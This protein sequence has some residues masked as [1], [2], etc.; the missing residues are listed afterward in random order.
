MLGTTSEPSMEACQARC[1]ST[2][3]CMTFT[4][5]LVPGKLPKVAGD[6]RLQSAMSWHSNAS[7][8]VLSGPARF[9]SCC[10]E[11]P[12]L[13]DA[14]FTFGAPAI[15]FPAAS[16]PGGRC[17]PGVRMYT[18]NDRLP[19]GGYGWQEDAAA[20]HT[21]YP[22]AKTPVF[23]LRD[24]NKST[25]QYY[26]CYH[27]PMSTDQLVERMPLMKGAM[28]HEWR[29]H[30]ITDVYAKRLAGMSLPN[31]SRLSKEKLDKYIQIGLNLTD[32]AD[33]TYTQNLS[34]AREAVRRDLP[35]WKLVGYAS[36]MGK[37]GDQDDV[38]LL[39]DEESGDCTISFE[40]SFGM[41]DLGSF[42]SD[43]GTGY[44]GFDDVHVGVRNELW[45]ITA[46]PGKPSW[47]SGIKS[48]LPKCRK[49]ICV[50]HSLGGALCELFTLCANSNR[51]GDPDF[52]KLAWKKVEPQLMPEVDDYT[53]RIARLWSVERGEPVAHIALPYWGIAALALSM[54][55][56]M[57]LPRTLHARTGDKEISI[58]QANAGSSGASEADSTDVEGQS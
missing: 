6:C 29:L 17:I 46:K 30:G 1:A 40:G 51:F 5:T 32:M 11:T 12:L 19:G 3:D 55:L 7:L 24:A 20:M 42:A 22:H 45:Y 8:P 43:Y 26:E 4:F 23:V 34:A 53:E 31:T 14:M 2:I 28:Y 54:M 44:C 49:V 16:N 39:Q 9:Q 37:A 56:A 18:E 15:S 21:R 48:K 36:V 52:N 10:T 35:G 58:I 33:K 47:A 13:V 27:T 50:G 25:S 41:P 38:L 57:M